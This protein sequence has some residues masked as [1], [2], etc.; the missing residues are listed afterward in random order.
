MNTSIELL[1][2]SEQHG[3]RTIRSITD[4][5]EK[6]GQYC[7]S[8]AVCTMIIGYFIN[9]RMM[10]LSWLLAYTCR[11]FM[12]IWRHALQ[13]RRPK[14]INWPFRIKRSNLVDA[15]FSI[16]PPA[17]GLLNWCIDNKLIRGNVGKYWDYVEEIVDNDALV[18][19]GI[20]AKFAMHQESYVYLRM[21][22][23]GHIQE[24]ID[25][26]YQFGHYKIKLHSETTWNDSTK[27]I[28]TNVIL[29]R[30]YV[31]AVYERCN[32]IIYWIGHRMNLTCICTESPLEIIKTKYTDKKSVHKISRAEQMVKII[33]HMFGLYDNCK[34]Q[35]YDNCL[36][37]G[38]RL[39]DF[40][41]WPSLVR[42]AA[43]NTQRIKCDL[44]L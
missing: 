1:Q 38:Q 14:H 29:G 43:E 20:K 42:L 41:A 17:I 11:D 25:K 40:G 7:P 32:F 35:L 36:Y 5:I 31:A 28:S 2:F 13:C 4:N 3:S 24:A 39:V 26:S 18:E 12:A 9:R 44:D 19:L 34:D 10:S 21:A 15:V 23:P 33:A 6:Y 30:L 27:L 16:N 22:K 37:L 8:A